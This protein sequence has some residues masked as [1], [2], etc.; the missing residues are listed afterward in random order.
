MMKS[1]DGTIEDFLT[2][3]RGYRDIHFHKIMNLPVYI[4]KM[5]KVYK[6]IST[7]RRD[8]SKKVTKI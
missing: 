6:Q 2:K 1:S 8:A 4:K 3:E 5:E 7:F